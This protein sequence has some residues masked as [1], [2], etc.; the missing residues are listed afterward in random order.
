MKVC[1]VNILASAV[2]CCDQASDVPGPDL[3]NL[4]EMVVLLIVVMPLYNVMVV[5]GFMFILIML[6]TFLALTNVQ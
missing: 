5:M 6:V 3:G 2:D 1:Y 4:I